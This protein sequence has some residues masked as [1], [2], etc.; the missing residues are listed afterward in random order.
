MYEESIEGPGRTAVYYQKE[1]GSTPRPLFCEGRD[2]NRLHSMGHVTLRNGAK[3]TIRGDSSFNNGAANNGAPTKIKMDNGYGRSGRRLFFVGFSDSKTGRFGTEE[4]KNFAG[5]GKIHQSA[6]LIL[7]NLLFD[8]ITVQPSIRHSQEGTKNKDDN[9]NENDQYFCSNKNNGKW[10]GTDENPYGANCDPNEPT[11]MSRG[12]R[13]VTENVLLKTNERHK[14]VDSMNGGLERFPGSSCFMLPYAFPGSN[15]GILPY[16]DCGGSVAMVVGVGNKLEVDTCEIIKS[17]AQT[18][19]FIIIG[20]SSI[21]VK[22]TV[23]RENFAVWFGGVF[24][25][26]GKAEAMLSNNIFVSNG[27]LWYG[28]IMYAVESSRIIMSGR[29]IFEKNWGHRYV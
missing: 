5:T 6:T 25:L 18:A 15:R 16:E 26:K 13:H 9:T 12:W 14:D 2:T 4:M 1:D 24:H 27:A 23:F 17:S 19:A 20:E 29:N 10:G 7:K 11:I 3:L 28:G 22:N 8:R 21:E